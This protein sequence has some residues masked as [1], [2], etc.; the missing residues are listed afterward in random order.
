MSKVGVDP[1]FDYNLL[2]G[3][4]SGSDDCWNTDQENSSS[5]TTVNLLIKHKKYNRVV[6]SVVR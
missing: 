1:V 3:N 6:W 4:I 5:I 2:D